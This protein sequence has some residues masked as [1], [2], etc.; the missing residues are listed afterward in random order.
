MPRP[1]VG[2]GQC[3]RGGGPDP[4]LGPSGG[5]RD[6]GRG[7]LGPRARRRG[8]RVR[9]GREALL[10]QAASEA[11]P[12]QEPPS[13]RSPGRGSPGVGP[14]PGCWAD[15]DGGEGRPR[16]GLPSP[17]V[18]SPPPAAAQ[19]P[20]RE[21]G[22]SC[23]STPEAQGSERGAEGSRSVHRHPLARVPLALAA[24]RPLPMCLKLRHWPFLLRVRCRLRQIFS[25]CLLC[26]RRWEPGGKYVDLPLRE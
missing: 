15:L 20:S 22:I 25:E 5:Q 23:G 8:T 9:R 1:H 24:R 6:L 16:Q 21:R 17:H 4:S 12:A 3:R 19:H 26:T 14:R 18:L 11:R 10:P 13:V 2:W 7:V